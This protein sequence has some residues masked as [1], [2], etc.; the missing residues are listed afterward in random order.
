[1]PAASSTEQSREMASLMK[2]RDALAAIVKDCT[3]MF[4]ELSDT[5][6]GSGLDNLRGAF[7]QEWL[8]DIGLRHLQ[9]QLKDI[10]GIILTMLNVEHIM[11]L[12]VSFNDAA[13][14]H[15][16]GFIAHCELN[17]DYTCSPPDGAVVSWNVQ[18]TEEWIK[19]LAPRFKCLA[20]AGW[21][22]AA[23]C[24]LSPFRVVEAS[25]GKLKLA[26]AVKF[27]SAVN[28]ERGSSFFQNPDS[29]QAKWTGTATIELQKPE[30]KKN[31]GRSR[32]YRRR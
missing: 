24:S 32:M 6:S 20:A 25:K 31:R 28:S 19:S 4:E 21:H 5:L 30:Y 15:L 27:L 13:A 23:L 1:M 8:C 7:F 22:G 9:T 26:D 10:D 3:N 29:W 14:L 18:R 16:R 12:G 17:E 2:R 11:E